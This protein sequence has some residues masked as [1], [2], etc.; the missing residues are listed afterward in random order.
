MLAPTAMNR[1]NFH[2]TLLPN[3]K[4]KATAKPAPFAGLDLG[5]AK[6]HFELGAGKENFTNSNFV[7]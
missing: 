2:F 7:N 1:Q 5:I 4:V 6:L 3:N